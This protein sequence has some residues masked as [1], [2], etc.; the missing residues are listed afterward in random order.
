MFLLKG[1]KHGMLMTSARLPSQTGKGIQFPS[2]QYFENLS[3]IPI[4]AE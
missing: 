4:Q 3:K 1:E 2:P